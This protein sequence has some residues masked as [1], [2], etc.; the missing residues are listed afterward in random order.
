[1]RAFL[2]GAGGFLAVTGSQFY[3]YPGAGPLACIISSFVAGTGWKWR[4]KKQ[5]NQ[6]AIMPDEV[7]KVREDPVEKIFESIWFALQP[8]LFASIGTEIKF[9]LL[10]GSDIIFTGILVL[11]AGLIVSNIY[12]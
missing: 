10:M 11:V 5:S 6:I 3:G 7:D 2:L 12:V 8:V 9:E 4:V 1:M